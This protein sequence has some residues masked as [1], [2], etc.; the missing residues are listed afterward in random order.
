M[1]TVAPV[2]TQGLTHTQTSLSLLG[3]TIVS[4]TLALFIRR[5]VPR[6]ASS[7]TGH[8]TAVR[9]TL[10][11]R[12][13]TGR[14]GGLGIGAG[15]GRGTLNPVALTRAAAGWAAILLF[16]VAGVAASGTFIGSIVL[17]LAHTA[18]SFFRWA[19]SLFPGG[20]HDAATIGVSIVGLLLLWWGLHLVADLIEGRIHHGGRDWLVFAGPMLFTLVPGYFG[21]WSATAYAAIGSHVGPIVAHL[22]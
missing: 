11:G 13:G 9:G 5:R 3:I 17:W 6:L 2:V 15:G 1:H 19:I 10:G 4:L 20:G 21:Q 12:G 22:V 18:D 16:A 8:F 14:A 7:I